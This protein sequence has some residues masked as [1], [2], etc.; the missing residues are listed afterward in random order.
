MTDMNTKTLPK[1]AY[2]AHHPPIERFNEP[3]VVFCTVCILNRESLLN[4]HSALDAVRHAWQA[5]G[6]W[7]VGEFLFMPDHIHVFCVPGVL[8]PESLKA[9]CRYWK[10]LASQHL[11]LLKGKWQMDVWD[12]QMRN[13]DHYVEKLVYVRQNPVRRG[14]VSRWDDWPYRGVMHEIVW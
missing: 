3:T 7:R 13:A 9:W 6:Q 12:T 14:L 4:N 2:P 8:H 1:R 11:P 10:R 5:A